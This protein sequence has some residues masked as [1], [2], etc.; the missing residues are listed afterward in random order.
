M[1][2][3]LIA[4][5]FGG[6]FLANGVPHFVAGI[7]GHAFQTPFSKPPGKGYSSSYVNVIWGG[8]QF[9]RRL[10]PASETGLVR[11]WE[12]LPFWRFLK[13]CAANGFGIGKS[14]WRYSRRH[15][16][17]ETI[18][19]QDGHM[20]HKGKTAIV[21]GAAQGIGEAYAH[22]LASATCAPARANS[23]AVSRP[24]PEPA[25]VTIAT[26]SFN[27]L[28]ISHLFFFFYLCGLNV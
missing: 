18:R 22:G 20:T 14:L 12:L 6:V 10:F 24:M 4:Y 27:P 3:S 21:T 19:K 13:R 26:F 8:V 5:F 9:C 1:D 17:P 28:D 7:S 23:R 11:D 25:P 15:K 2:W 16:S